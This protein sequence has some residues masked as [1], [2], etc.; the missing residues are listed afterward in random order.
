MK[1]IKNNERRYKKGV[2]KIEKKISRVKN[3]FRTKLIFFKTFWGKP[4]KLTILGKNECENVFLKIE[5]I[6]V[7]MY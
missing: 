4:E 2:K 3:S 5:Q 1:I 7:Y 6:Y